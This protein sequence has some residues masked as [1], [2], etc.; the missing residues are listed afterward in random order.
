MFCI[1]IEPHISETNATG[2]IDNA[3]V[4]VWLERAR[5]PLYRLFNPDLSPEHWNLIIKRL[6]IDFIS[7]ISYR[8]SITIKGHIKEIRS[9]SFT[10][11][12][13]I[14]QNGEIVARGSTVLVHYDYKMHVKREIP[15]AVREKLEQI[16][17][18]ATS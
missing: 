8:N 5:S 15:L 1:E 11:I 14:F 16:I 2:H 7:P 13:E 6:E 18:P 10:A 3:A 17:P 12:Q 9:S 4:P